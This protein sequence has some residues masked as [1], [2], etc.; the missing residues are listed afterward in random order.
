MLSAAGVWSSL[1]AEYA[2]VADELIGLLGAVQTG[3]WQGPSAAAYV[4]AHAPYLA[5]LMRASETSAEAAARHETV[6]A[7]YT[8][9]VAAMQIFVS[10]SIY[11]V[12]ACDRDVGKVSS[13]RVQV[14]VSLHS[15][16]GLFFF[17]LKIFSCRTHNQNMSS[18]RKCVL[19]LR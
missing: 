19:E 15:R 18:R 4:A 5:W 10:A 3:A 2:A 11:G 17:Y 12:V 16:R 7:A 1:S 6:A 13:V 14:L 8:T 9:A